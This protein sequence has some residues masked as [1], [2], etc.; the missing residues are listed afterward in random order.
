MLPEQLNAF[1]FVNNTTSSH[2][3]RDRGEN[4]NWNDEKNQN[5]NHYRTIHT[6]IPQFT[7][8]SHPEYCPATFQALL[9]PHNADLNAANGNTTPVN[10]TQFPVSPETLINYLNTTDGLPFIDKIIATSTNKLEN[11]LEVRGGSS[12]GLGEMTTVVNGPNS[13]RI[14][15]S[16]GGINLSV[17]GRD[18]RAENSLIIP[19]TQVVQAFNISHRPYTHIP[20]E[21]YRRIGY[22]DISEICEDDRTDNSDK[23]THK[24]HKNRTNPKQILNTTL[25]LLPHSPYDQTQFQSSLIKSPAIHSI[26]QPLG[27][28]K[29]K[30][31][32]DQS[33]LNT[34][35]HEF[36]QNSLQNFTS[37]LPLYSNLRLPHVITEGSY[38][39]EV[40]EP[41][42]HS[43]FARITSEIAKNK[44]IHWEN[45]G[46]NHKN[47]DQKNEQ[48]TTQR[49]PPKKRPLLSALSSDEEFDESALGSD[50]DTNSDICNLGSDSDIEC[51]PIIGSFDRNTRILAK[52]G[53][54]SPS[55]QI[56]NNGTHV[57]STSP[58]AT[59]YG[60]KNDT[61]NDL[62][63]PTKEPKLL[64]SVGS[65]AISN[66]P[67]WHFVQEE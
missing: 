64:F 27:I 52:N 13:K 32:I 57:S 65:D 31:K 54:N 23:K 33:F 62:Q 7:F 66:I 22:N 43:D 60:T 1:R 25:Y 4:Q 20:R 9:L 18:L 47:N 24:S 6:K 38:D 26:L 55:S 45:R 10:L 40:V 29:S 14:V 61:K 16:R 15:N 30:V 44:D 67:L 63:I 48:K 56:T 17:F 39:L 49:P 12:K 51:G 42:Y 37:T 11:G 46:K 5:Y 58:S 35:S 28:V 34:F 36:F 21:Y 3:R 19:K 59:K 2:F 50:S 41:E 8:P 53:V